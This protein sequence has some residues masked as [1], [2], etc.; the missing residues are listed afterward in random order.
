M[1]KKRLHNQLLFVYIFQA[2][3]VVLAA[4]SD[5]F[6]AMFTDPMK[7]RHQNEI[8]L[9]G[10]DADGLELVLEYIYT[11]KLSLTLA[12]IQTVLSTATHL[13]IIQ[14]C[15]QES[16]DA[17]AVVNYFGNFLKS[18]LTRQLSRNILKRIILL[19]LQVIGACSAYLRRQLDLINC[20][21]VITLAETYAL[22]RLRRFTYNFISENLMNLTLQQIH[23]LTLEQFDYLLGGDFPINA[24]ELSIL[25]LVLQWT[26]QESRSS[27]I[28]ALLSRIDFAQISQSELKELVLTQQTANENVS[29]MLAE[30]LLQ[31]DQSVEFRDEQ[32]LLNLRGMQ[33]SIVKVFF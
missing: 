33:L 8:N 5:Y 17:S 6:R 30:K 20:V 32:G 27:S 9:S 11:S 24:S 25:G 4:C 16:A 22:P 2:H 21:D 3:R 15:F 28:N 23:R 7:E 31:C 19:I 14:V 18:Q 10:V 13:Q 1:T 26:S 12:N 29:S